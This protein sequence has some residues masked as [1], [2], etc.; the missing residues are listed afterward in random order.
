MDRCSFIVVICTIKQFHSRI[1]IVETLSIEWCNTV[2]VQIVHLCTRDILSNNFLLQCLQII[3][4]VEK[5][6]QLKLTLSMRIFDRIDYSCAWFKSYI[7]YEWRSRKIKMVM[8]FILSSYFKILQNILRIFSFLN[9]KFSLKCLF[10]ILQA[11]FV[12]STPD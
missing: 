5:L 6:E 7:L 10:H 11:F 8:T 9:V 3:S 2:F 12:R 4:K 1:K